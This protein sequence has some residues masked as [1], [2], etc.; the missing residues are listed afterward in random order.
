VEQNGDPAYDHRSEQHRSHFLGNPSALRFVLL[1]E[2][3]D[4]G[5]KTHLRNLSN[6]Y[7]YK[8]NKFEVSQKEK[9]VRA[10]EHS[11]KINIELSY[12]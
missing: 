5:L 12:I 10:I 3:V 7:D 9:L 2:E 8:G 11:L 1:A 6:V 4:V